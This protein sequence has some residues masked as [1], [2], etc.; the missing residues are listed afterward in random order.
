[1]VKIDDIY[2]I[3]SRPKGYEFNYLLVTDTNPVNRYCQGW[4][5]ATLEDAKREREK[6]KIQRSNVGKYDINTGEDITNS[7]NNIKVDFSKPITDEI[8]IE[9]IKED[10]WSLG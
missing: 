1:M 3:V 4:F 2:P 8:S 6:G 5:F 7:F 9:T 10:I